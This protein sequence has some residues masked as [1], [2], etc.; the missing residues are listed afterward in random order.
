MLKVISGQSRLRPEMSKQAL[1][2]Q[3]TIICLVHNLRTASTSVA[4]QGCH[5]FNSRAKYF[6]K[7]K[8]SS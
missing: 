8:L 1:V 5:I 2:V 3:D 4:A 6:I 7:V